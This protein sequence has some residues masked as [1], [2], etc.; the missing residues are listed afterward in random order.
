[1]A[2]LQIIYWRDI[3]AQAIVSAG[4]RKARRQLDV[5][6]EKAI[7]RAAIRA[8]LHGTDDYLEQ[9]RRGAPV[10]CGDD[11][12]AAVRQAAERIERDYPQ[13]R[14]ERLVRANGI[15]EERHKDDEGSDESSDDRAA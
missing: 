3:P 5:R 15:D 12:E 8:K 4:R 11:L 1:M 7:D 10:A 14:V 9:W 13:E 2:K 6:F